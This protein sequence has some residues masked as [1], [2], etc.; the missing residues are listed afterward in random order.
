M[1][2]EGQ[3]NLLGGDAAAVVADA[4]QRLAP[5]ADLH[6]HLGRPGINGIVHQLL[7]LLLL[8][9]VG[10]HLQVVVVQ[11]VRGHQQDLVA[12]LERTVHHADQHHDAD[13]VVEP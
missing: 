10:E 6:P 4:D 12:W 2:Q 13:V 8:V 5:L 1:A 11:G 3:R 7:D 9:L